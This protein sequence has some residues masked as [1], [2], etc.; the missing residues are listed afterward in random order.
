MNHALIFTFLLALPPLPS[1]AIDGPNF[2]WI[3]SADNRFFGVD[4]YGTNKAN[5]PLIDR[6]AQEGCVTPLTVCFK[7]GPSSLF[8][9]TSVRPH[10][11]M[12]TGLR[13]F[14]TEV[15][16]WWPE[17]SSTVRSCHSAK[18]RGLWTRQRDVAPGGG[19]RSIAVAERLEVHDL[20][21]ALAPL[22]CPF[23]SCVAGVCVKSACGKRA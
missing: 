15:A 19:R 4:G 7:A 3:S 12:S 20:R 2:L 21:A 1:L 5:T 13:L 17:F 14:V 6:L 16:V 18:S 8:R 9:R 22:Q 10:E 11:F 23:R